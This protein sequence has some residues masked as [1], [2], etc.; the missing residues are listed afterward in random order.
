MSGEVSQARALGKVI[1]LGEHAVVYGSPAIALALSVGARASADR[2]A[3][4]SLSLGRQ[5]QVI[6]KSASEGEPA[7]RA[8]AEL[9]AVLGASNVAASAELDLPAG[10]GLGAS[11]A[12]GVALAR[13]VAGLNGWDPSAQTRIAEAALAW[14]QVFHGNASG[15]DTAVAEHGGCLWFTRRDG[16]SPLAPARP[17]SVIAAQ[18]EPGQSTRR[19]VEGVALSRQRDPGRVDAWLTTIAQLTEQARSAI[20]AGDLGQL[21]QLMRQN[22]EILVDLGVSTAGLNQA[23]QRA[24]DAGA[25]GAKLT[26]AGGGGCVLA[27]V[28]AGGRDAVLEA[29]RSYPCWAASTGVV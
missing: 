18:V 4:S 29:W 9:L 15:I 8:F 28:D 17:L 13:A 14:E 22:H 10:A 24:L 16:P 1:L 11:A 26:G 5:R 3:L 23:V 19:M 21:G 7:A 25:L 27:L 2:A 12:L 20:L 6:G